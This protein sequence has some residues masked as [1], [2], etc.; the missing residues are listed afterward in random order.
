MLTDGFTLEGLN[1]TKSERQKRLT[2][3][4]RPLPRYRGIN[5]TVIMKIKRYQKHY[6]K[7]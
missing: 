4:V 5:L 6:Q 2:P 3:K 7:H 1:R